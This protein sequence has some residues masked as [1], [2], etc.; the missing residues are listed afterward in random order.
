[1]LG[2]MKFASEMMYKGNGVMSATKQSFETLL[3]SAETIILDGAMGTELDKLGCTERCESNLFNPD[4]VVRVH[5]DYLQAGSAAIITNTLTMNR[6]FI[7]SHKLEIDVGKV[8]AAGVALARRATQ[9]SGYVL[10]NLSSTG[11]ILEPYGSY[12]EQTVTDCFKEQAG[13]LAEGG[14]DG[15]IIETMFDLREAICALRACRATAELPVV[16]CIAYNTEKNGGRTV[17]GNSAPEC[18]RTLE[19]E[20]AHAI[21]ANCGNIGP[22]QMAQIVTTLSSV[23]RLPIVAEPNAGMPRLVEGK[24]VFDMDAHAFA[25]GLMK[26]VKSGARILVV[27]AEARLIT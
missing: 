2:P 19:S 9:G 22:D 25:S 20:G 4:A 17:M 3:L 1:M 13:Y 12:S 10:G 15:F 16:V 8:N 14:V 27:A 18:A 5:E 6:V 7:E 26:C 23:T 21:G 11:Q 24:T